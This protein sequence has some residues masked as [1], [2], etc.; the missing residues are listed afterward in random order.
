MIAPNLD[1]EDLAPPEGGTP[2][3][4]AAR[5]LRIG[6]HCAALPDIDRRTPDEIMGY[7]ETGMWSL[8]GHDNP[9]KTP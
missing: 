5:L 7:D 2:D 4:V 8:T 6:A 9:P 1:D 3:D